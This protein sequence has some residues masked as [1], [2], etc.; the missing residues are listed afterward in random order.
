MH[1]LKGFWIYL[2]LNQIVV[3]GGMA[4]EERNRHIFNL[5]FDIFWHIDNQLI[6]FYDYSFKNANILLDLMGNPSD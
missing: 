5:I 1:V 3:L 2:K 6:L 4:M